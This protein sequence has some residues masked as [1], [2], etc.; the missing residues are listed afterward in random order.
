MSDYSTTFIRP[1]HNDRFS[2]LCNLSDNDFKRR[3]SSLDDKTLNRLHNIYD[4][5]SERELMIVDEFWIRQPL[6]EDDDELDDDEL[7][8]EIKDASNHTVKV[9]AFQIELKKRCLV[10]D[11]KKATKNELV[12]GQFLMQSRRFSPKPELDLDC[13]ENTEDD[14]FDDE[15]K[16]PASSIYYPDEEEF[17]YH[18]LHFCP[19]TQLYYDDY[20]RRRNEWLDR[21]FE[22]LYAQRELEQAEKDYFI[23]SCWDAILVNCH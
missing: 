6:D 20:M 19:M 7:D 15:E 17:D 22:E 5:N 18:D 21:Y 13:E 14:D 12:T 16:Q 11:K 4:P 8:D 1:G 2:R 23:E 3:L 10:Y 9:R